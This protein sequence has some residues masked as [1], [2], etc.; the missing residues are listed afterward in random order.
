MIQEALRLED[1]R[2]KMYFINFLVGQS[3]FED[4]VRWAVYCKISPSRLPRRLVDYIQMTPDALV[5]AERNIQRM[6]MRAAEVEEEEAMELLPGFP[7]LTVKTWTQLRALIDKFDNEPQI[8]ID[9]EWKPQYIAPCESIALLQIALA[10]AVYLVDFCLLEKEMDE[11]HWLL[12]LRA[13]LCNSSMKIGFDLTNDLRALFASPST[14]PL[15]YVL[16][17]MSNVVCLKL[18]VTNLLEVDRRFF[19]NKSFIDDNDGGDDAQDTSDSDQTVHFKL[20]ELSENLLGVKLDKSEQCSNWAIRPLRASQ[21]RYAAMDAYIV[22]ELFNKLK[23]TAENR[24]V[25]F[26]EA[27]NRSQVSVKKKDKIK[28]KKER[29]KFEDMK[30]AKICEKLNGV[31][32]GTRKSTDLHC[33]VDSMLLGLGKNLRRC[34]VNVLIPENRNELKLKA[35]EGERIILTCGKAYNELKRLFP[36]R[37]LFFARYNVTFSGLDVFSRCID[38]NNTCIVKAP[39][40]VIQALF[41]NVV[42]CRSS[43]HDEAFDIAEWSK[44]LSSVDPDQYRGIGCQLILYDDIGVV[45]E[46]YGG[47]IDIIANIVT[48]DHLEEGVEVA[49]KRV[50]E[51]VVSRVGNVFYICALCGKVYWD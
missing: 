39:G 2:L 28:I 26:D 6:E 14:H 38:C 3:S 40:I 18:L 25:D 47:T 46:C 36:D 10:D 30:W 17:E 50:P 9:S 12:F 33:I 34:G 11:N 35:T 31:L 24:D 21:K 15:R 13:L 16:D 8:G 44:R 48:H 29:I 22:V 1:E 41:D 42:T 49:V 19:E 27:V 45:V 43:F 5:N 23:I 4:A 7:I 20:S 51:P 37:V 32:C